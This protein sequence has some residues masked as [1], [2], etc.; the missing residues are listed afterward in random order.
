MVYQRVITPNFPRPQG[1]PLAPQLPQQRARHLAEAARV[2]R[3]EDVLPGIL[4]GSAGRPQRK[5]WKMMDFTL[6]F[7]RKN[8]VS[9]PRKSVGNFG[10]FSDFEKYG[11]V[12]GDF[13]K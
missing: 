12:C 1:L 6:D 8:G 13:I 5:C 11:D 9:S 3:I 2:A 4:L 7:T 10:D